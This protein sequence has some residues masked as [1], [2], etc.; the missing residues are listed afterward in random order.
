M[1]LKGINPFEQHAEK[2]VLGL[3]SLVFL[4]VLAMQFLL[5]PNAITS[6]GESLT[7]GNV[8]RN[9]RGEAT[10]VA[11][12]MEQGRP[13]LP[14][15]GAT[16]DL[17]S[18][19]QEMVTSTAPAEPLPIAMGPSVSIDAQPIAFDQSLAIAPVVVPAPTNAMAAPFIATVDPYAI[20]D[21][22]GLERYVTQQPY[23]LR[24]VT[25]EAGFDGDAFRLVL[26]GDGLDENVR[27]MN[28]RWWREGLEVI[29]VDAERERY[30][31]V[32]Q[33]WGSP[34]TVRRAP[35][36]TDLL[37]EFAERWTSS[38]PTPEELGRLIEAAGQRG[39][40]ILEP[41][42]YP[43][44][45]GSAWQPPSE[46]GSVQVTVDRADRL[47]ELARQIDQQ[48]ARIAAL[49]AGPREPTA[50]SGG[51]DDPRGGGARGGVDNP[52]G[53]TN[54]GRTAEQAAQ[55]RRDTQAQEL[56][57]RLEILNEEFNAMDPSD[58]ERFEL[59]LLRAARTQQ[60]AIRD[61]QRSTRPS[62]RQSV[63]RFGTDLGGFV[64]DLAGGGRSERDTFGT[65]GDR[66][67]GAS[68]GRRSALLYNK[69]VRLWV[70]DLDVEPGAVY[71]Y[72]TRVTINNP[73]YQRGDGLGNQQELGNAPLL[74]GAWSDWSNPVRVDPELY[75]FV[76]AA[77][78]RGQLSAEPLASVEMYRFWYG[79]WRRGDSNFRPGMP[80]EV[81][82]ENAR[83]QMPVVDTS[84]VTDPGE[85]FDY[86]RE[87]ESHRLAMDAWRTAQNQPAGR[88]D[89]GATPGGRPGISNIDPGSRNPRSTAADAGAEPV[90][91]DAIDGIAQMSVGRLFSKLY[92]LDVVALPFPQPAPN[93][94]IER[95]LVQGDKLFAERAAARA[96]QVAEQ[97]GTPVPVPAATIDQAAEPSDELLDRWEVVFVGSGGEFIRR[98][99]N[100][101]RISLDYR[102]LRLSARQGER[103]TVELAP[104]AP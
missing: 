90:A 23:D 35:G 72:R 19:F 99:T 80:L 60:Q 77:S 51:V 7:P 100:A 22:P 93:G 43:L 32:A 66:S 10:N 91:P 46:R 87:L 83:L 17:A 67:R 30:D 81:M 20:S 40:E 26:E 55:E 61:R 97:A 86:T 65:R 84:T 42:Y 50:R 62:G 29:S 98:S 82:P 75:F 71:R 76:N 88:D 92:L 16:P 74:V 52:G 68:T 89:P 38:Q 18:Q 34:V 4:G 94:D 37:S 79:Y 12:Q 54:T 41:R 3:V 27:P 13:A 85:F 102:R 63:G 39:S 28:P 9:I 53:R 59:E 2:I 14:D 6:G 1:K 47:L 103:Q 64:D 11:S 70:H 31:P 44:I 69:S 96:A 104:I 5:Q 24:S 95:M 8:Y 25:I 49:E 48:E 33:T 36:T 21:I 45:A 101:D 57:D 56:A 73:M 15:F 78:E 58:D